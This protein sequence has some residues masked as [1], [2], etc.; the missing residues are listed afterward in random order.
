M[1]KRNRVLGALGG[2]V[3]G[4]LILTFVVA[5][6]VDFGKNLQ[7]GITFVDAIQKLQIL[8]DLQQTQTYVLTQFLTLGI[9]FVGAIWA[10]VWLILGAFKKHLIEIL[11]FVGTCAAFFFFGLVAFFHGEAL[12]RNIC[13]PVG[14]T[15]DGAVVGRLI[16]LP[17]ICLILLAGIIVTFA[18]DMK[19]IFAKDDPVIIIEPKEYTSEALFEEVFYEEKPV[20]EPAVVDEEAIKE[21]MEKVDQLI[22][23]EELL[24]S[25]PLTVDNIPA[26]LLKEEPEEVEDRPAILDAPVEEEK[27]ETE[28]PFEHLPFLDK[29]MPEEEEEEPV[30]E[31]LPI[32]DK[33]MPEEKEEEPVY[34]HLP[35]LDKK[36]E[37]QEDSIPDFL[38]TESELKASSE[39]RVSNS[40]K[41]A[42]HSAIAYH[43]S[44]TTKGYQVK[45]AGSKDVMGSYKTESEAV[46]AIRKESPDSSIRIHDKNGKIRSL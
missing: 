27:E 5:L 9:F 2:V 1:K 17:I 46:N 8:F 20:E 44:K 30:Y 43:I 34:E 26:I 35:I 38:K 23:E 25:A 32:L 33:P 12:L 16:V 40:K 41:V 19:R 37:A 7:F 6:V 45:A 22:A 3:F 11:F 21:V 31:H 10:L 42:R 29:P 18:Y 28:E 14:G 15:I 4:L 24:A 39:D 36:E 13:E